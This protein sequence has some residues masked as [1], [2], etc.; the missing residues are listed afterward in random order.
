MMKGW[1]S[2]FKAI[3]ALIV[4]ALVLSGCGKPFLSAL[5]PKVKV[6]K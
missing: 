2:K 5:Q 4:L 3:F 6:Q 1:M